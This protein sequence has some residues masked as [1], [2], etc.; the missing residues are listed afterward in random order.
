MIFIQTYLYI[1]QHTVTGKLYF[2]KTTQ[3]PLTYM[4]S[5]L[6][7]KHHIRKHGKSHVITLW[8][9]LYDNV[10]DLVADAL[11]MSKAFDIVESE[12]WLNMKYEN[13]LDGNMCGIY[14]PLFGKSHTQ[15]TKDKI[16]HS[17]SGSSNPFY[18]KSHSQETKD[19]LANTNSGYKS[20]WKDRHHSQETKDKITKANK[21]KV[22]SDTTKDKISKQNTIYFDILTPTGILHEHVSL[23][24]ISKVYSISY[25]MLHRK[26]KE[27]KPYKGFTMLKKHMKEK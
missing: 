12:T 15:E 16:S 3:N 26:F 5:G 17:I 27:N 22:P 9:Q 18:G 14:H 20:Y 10:F 11:S 25:D 24:F 2:G 8:Y 21:N 1:K 4:G 7:W 6:H 13:G 19:K 23:Y